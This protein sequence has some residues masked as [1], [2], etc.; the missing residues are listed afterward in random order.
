MLNVFFNQPKKKKEK[1]T[2]KIKKNYNLTAKYKSASNFIGTE[3]NI[4]KAILKQ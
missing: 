1:Y 2:Y 3:T 4:K